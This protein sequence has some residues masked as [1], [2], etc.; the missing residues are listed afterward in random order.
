MKNMLLLGFAFNHDIINIYLYC[1]TY[2]RFEDLCHQS[3]ISG[4]SVFEFE[5]HDFVAIETMWC[6]ESC[7]LYVSR[8]HGNL[9]VSRE[10]VQE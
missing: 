2:Q 4:A 10:G 8:G 3:L 7:F 9:V 1:V 6:Y 5:W